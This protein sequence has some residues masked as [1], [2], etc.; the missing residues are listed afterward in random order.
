MVIKHIKLYGSTHRQI[1]SQGFLLFTKLKI[2]GK[3][4]QAINLGKKNTRSFRKQKDIILFFFQIDKNAFISKMWLNYTHGVLSLFWN[5]LAAPS[6]TRPVEE[7]SGLLV[8]GTKVSLLQQ[9]NPHSY[10]PGVFCDVWRVVLDSS[11]R[12]RGPTLRKIG[13]PHPLL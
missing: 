7:Q 8:P 13:S 2:K 5:H 10:S 4:N 9:F 1:Y 3:Y 11:V 6:K 12:Q